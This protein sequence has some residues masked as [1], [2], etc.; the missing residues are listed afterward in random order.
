MASLSVEQQ[1]EAQRIVDIVM[2]KARVEIET[3]ARLVV[4]KADPE[5]F[6]K[7][8]F[9]L[10]DAMHRLGACVL[11]AALEQRKKRGTRVRP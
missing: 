5:L 7:T 11:D 9:V 6:G 1:A 10:R 2:A 3:A 4:S 8:E